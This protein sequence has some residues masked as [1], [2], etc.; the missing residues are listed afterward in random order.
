MSCEHSDCKYCR[1]KIP[2]VT[3]EAYKT[4]CKKCGKGMHPHFWNGWMYNPPA[5]KEIQERVMM[6]NRIKLKNLQ[7]LLQS[8]ETKR[9]RIKDLA[10]D[11]GQSIK[12]LLSEQNKD[13]YKYKV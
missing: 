13:W 2:N 8:I 10:V 9:K 4:C 7:L 6:A 12:I 3:E 5:K 11:L 1:C